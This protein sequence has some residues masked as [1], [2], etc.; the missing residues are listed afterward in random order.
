[1]S[2]DTCCLLWTTNT[3]YATI[4]LLQFCVEVNVEDYAD[5]KNRGFIEGHMKP[6]SNKDRAALMR[7]G[8][9]LKLTQHIFA[10][11]DPYHNS[12]WENFIQ[13]KKLEETANLPK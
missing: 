5:M 12:K 11:K 4:A 6:W 2:K 3:R 13:K 9:D 1:M 10:P 7:H 8:G